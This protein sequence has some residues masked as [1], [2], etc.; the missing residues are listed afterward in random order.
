MWTVVGS[1]FVDAG[2]LALVLVAAVTIGS[3]T[4]SRAGTQSALGG[5]LP[6]LPRWTGTAMTIG[7]LVLL[8]VVAFQPV[9]TKFNPK[10]ANLIQ[11]LRSAGLSR[12]DTAMLERGY[13][14]DLTRVDRFNSQLWELYMR[15]PVK[16]LDGFENSGLLRFTG[17][18]LNTELMPSFASV[19][20]YGTIRTNRWGM[21][22]RDYEKQPAPGTDRIAVLGAS[23]V[24]GW[25]VGDGETF[26]AIVEER[27][28]RE[29][30]GQP[31]ERYEILN[32]AV[33]GYQPLQQLA[34]LDKVFAFGPSV[35]IYVATGREPRSASEY[36]VKAIRAGLP[37]P[38]DFLRTTALRAQI[39]ASTDETTALRRLAPF[40]WEV[41]TWLYRDIAQRCRQQGS[42]PVWVFLPQVNDRS[43]W[44][45]EIA[46]VRRIAEEAGFAIIDLR[47][48]YDGYPVAAV[49]LAEWDNHPNALGHRYVAERLYTA[50][51]EHDILAPAFAETRR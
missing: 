13:Y 19:T 7:S 11:S 35:V 50:L 31:Y 18:F 17:D 43:P 3:A 37:V 2:P 12:V 9:Y 42:R 6:R 21:R 16:W 38:Y 49:S 25:G 8:M 41:L 20:R 44:Q 28:N 1:A 4:S 39:D 40:R 30:V 27:L 15:K 10:V 51:L 48:V 26:E 24:M 45:K 47:D 23:T 29:R 32:F 22:D 36:L 46:Q 5:P 34:V 14:E 33:P